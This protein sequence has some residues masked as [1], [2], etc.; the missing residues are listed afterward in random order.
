M[1]RDQ[2]EY[3]RRE[4]LS[5]IEDFPEAADRLHHL[6]NYV[7]ESPC[8]CHRTQQGQ[9]APGPHCPTASTLGFILDEVV[10]PGDWIK[11]VAI[12]GQTGLVTITA[13]TKGSD[14]G[15]NVQTFNLRGVSDAV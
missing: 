15:E 6:R 10:E 8:I 11:A 1:R 9:Q 14:G 5:I 12:N 3:F 7:A 2:Q 13:Y 4:I